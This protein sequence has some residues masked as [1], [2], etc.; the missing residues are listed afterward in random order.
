MPAQIIDQRSLGGSPPPTD[1]TGQSKLQE[2]EFEDYVDI[3]DDWDDNGVL[4]GFQW[5][6]EYESSEDDVIDCPEL[7]DMP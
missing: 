3:I 2:V 7:A 5:F 4:S 1:E 6:L